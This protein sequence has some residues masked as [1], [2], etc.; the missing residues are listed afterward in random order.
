MAFTAP[1]KYEDDTH[2][3][4]PERE[5]VH[6]LRECIDLQNSKSRDYQNPNSTVRQA[7]Y[8]R[9]GMDSIYDMLHTKML[10]IKSLLEAVKHGGGKPN[11]ESIEDTL[12]DLINYSSFGVAWLRKGIDGQRDD[13]DIFNVP[14]PPPTDG[15]A[16]QYRNLAAPVPLPYPLK[17]SAADVVKS[18]P[19]GVTED[20]R[21]KNW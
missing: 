11:H 4:A 1:P 5:S 12:K 20:G 21:I 16:E 6:V 19:Y 15:F 14:L 2:T 7:D 10:R 3:A 17:G 18:S 9:L 8:Y 13:V